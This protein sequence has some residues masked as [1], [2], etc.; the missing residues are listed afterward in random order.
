[1]AVSFLPVLLL[2]VGDSLMNGWMWRPLEADAIC[3]GAPRSK[4]V[5]NHHENGLVRPARSAPVCSLTLLGELLSC[6]FCM[7]ALVIV[8]SM[9]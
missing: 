9:V 4:G 3:R 5:A 7:W 2:R 1:V 8:F 6:P